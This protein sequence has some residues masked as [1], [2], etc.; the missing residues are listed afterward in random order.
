MGGRRALTGAFL[1]P[2]R[3]GRNR[4]SRSVATD[5]VRQGVQCEDV[6]LAGHTEPHHRLPLPSP[7][8]ASDQEHRRADFYLTTNRPSEMPNGV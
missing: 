1:R 8:E 3:T 2:V 6:H 5:Q 7:A 4:A